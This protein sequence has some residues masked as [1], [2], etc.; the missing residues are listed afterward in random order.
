LYYLLA[1]LLS[2]ILVAT[3]Q[4]ALKVILTCA[5]LPYHSTPSPQQSSITIVDNM[6]R[7][8]RKKG[9]LPPNFYLD[10]RT[11]LAAQGKTSPKAA[12]NTKKGLASMLKKWKKYFVFHRSLPLSSLTISP[13]RF[14]DELDYNLETFL[15]NAQV[16][17]FKIF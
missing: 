8:Q 9:R 13:P 3:L 5:S 12:N 6:G 14:C 7:T 10:Q 1:P 4:S 11:Q 16:P 17:N 2:F 15:T